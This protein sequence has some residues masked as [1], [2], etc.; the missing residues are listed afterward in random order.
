[1]KGTQIPHSEAEMQWLEENRL[2]PIADYHRAF[3][4]EVRT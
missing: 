4:R 2:L 1:M 3:L